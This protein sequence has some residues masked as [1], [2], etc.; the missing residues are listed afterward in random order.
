VRP[1]ITL[2]GYFM[3]GSTLGFN[4]VFSGNPNEPPVPQNLGAGPVPINARPPSAN[5]SGAWVADEQ[6][7]ARLT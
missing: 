2:G 7:R 6:A 5:R 4:V 3:Y 1:G